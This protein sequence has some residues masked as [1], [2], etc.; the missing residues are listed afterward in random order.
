MGG[1]QFVRFPNQ[2]LLTDEQ[3]DAIFGQMK[4]HAKR[5]WVAPNG[6]VARWW[7]ER[8]RVSVQMDGA[9]GALRLSV[10]V[11]GTAP[12]LLQPSVTVN[13]PYANDVLKLVP[14]GPQSATV[15]MVSLDPWRTAVSLGQLSPGTHRWQMQFERAANVNNK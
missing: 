7:L 14:L 1:L 5:L 15:T 10:T 6:A 4:T 12:L 13:L 9:N 11:A 2:T 3:L 8:N